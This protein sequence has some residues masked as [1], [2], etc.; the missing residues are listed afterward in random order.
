[1]RINDRNSSIHFLAEGD[2]MQFTT[3]GTEGDEAVATYLRTIFPSMRAAFREKIQL[4]SEPFSNGYTWALKRVRD[5]LPAEKVWQC[6]TWIIP[7]G[8]D[9]F[10][11][12]FYQLDVEPNAQASY[13]G[14]VKMISFY[15]DPK[16]RY[17]YLSDCV[18]REL[19]GG[20]MMEGCLSRSG[21][22][23]QELIDMVVERVLFLRYCG[24]DTRAIEA[25]GEATHGWQ[26]YGNDTA[27]PVEIVNSVWLQWVSAG[28]S[29][30]GDEKRPGYFRMQSYGPGGRE[31]LDW[32]AAGAGASVEK[33]FP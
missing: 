2:G 4:L 30:Y 16:E 32:V 25:G 17:P 31:Q 28:E 10:E 29:L 1:M 14:K 19:N 9:T 13:D 6:G 8:G 15:N 12:I 26:W 27:L 23:S 11:T 18:I 22:P 21:L 33:N 20:V 7:L 3:G 24:M 5:I